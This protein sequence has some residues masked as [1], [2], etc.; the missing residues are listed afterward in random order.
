MSLFTF[1]VFITVRIQN[2]SITLR[3]FLLALS[4]AVLETFAPETQCFAFSH[5]RMLN[6]RIPWCLASWFMCFRMHP[7]CCMSATS[8]LCTTQQYSNVR[9]DHNLHSLSSLM[10]TRSFAASG[11]YYNKAAINMQEQVLYRHIFI[12]PGGKT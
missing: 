4:L 9:A 10:D 3:S 1:G 7:C 2:V 11:G 6:N 8:L 5:Y 12:S